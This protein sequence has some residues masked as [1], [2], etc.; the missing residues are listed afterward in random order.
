MIQLMKR[1]LLLN[2][3]YLLVIC[4]VTPVLYVVNPPHLNILLFFLYSLVMH[5]LIFNGFY[6]DTK[7]KVNQWI[8]SLP[9]KKQ[10]VVLS[11]YLFFLLTFFVFMLY[12]WLYHLNLKSR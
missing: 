10:H 5:M 7:N 3:N 2:W 4:L 6:N 9:I 11:R 8:I 12:Q 1:D